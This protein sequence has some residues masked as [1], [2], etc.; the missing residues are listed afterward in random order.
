MTW[1]LKLLWQTALLSAVYW[2]CKFVVDSL[3]LP[4][5]AGVLGII[6]LFCLLLSGVIKEDYVSLAASMLLQHL[7]FFFIP[8]AVGLMNFGRV[9]YDYGRVLAAAIIISSLASLLGAAVLIRLL[10]KGPK[11]CNSR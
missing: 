3:H 5:P 9:F 1:T 10:D 2:G 7:V 6:T 11:A 4:V 8:I